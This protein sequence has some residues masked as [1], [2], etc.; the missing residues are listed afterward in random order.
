MLAIANVP[1]HHG[2]MEAVQSSGGRFGELREIGLVQARRNLRVEWCIVIL[3]VSEICLTL[4]GM[5]F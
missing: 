3:I 1:W 2:G 4:Y 5:I